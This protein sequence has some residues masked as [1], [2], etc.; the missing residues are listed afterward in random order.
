MLN[1]FNSLFGR[2]NENIKANVE[3]YTW[4]TC[5]YCIRA[6][7]L[8]GWKGVKYTE[9]KIDGDES[10]R[11]AMAERSNG[12]RSVPQIFINNEPIGG[13]DDL[14]ALDGQKKLDNLLAKCGTI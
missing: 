7:W 9:Y 5:P 2:Y 6:K 13:C 1:L 11:Q 14:Y 12:K 10:A 4:A 8:L 3:I